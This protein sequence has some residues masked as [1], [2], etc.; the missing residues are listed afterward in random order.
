MPSLL[1]AIFRYIERMPAGF[2]ADIARGSQFN[3]HTRRQSLASMPAR[4]RISGDACQ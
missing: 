1:D 2:A 3:A 4:F